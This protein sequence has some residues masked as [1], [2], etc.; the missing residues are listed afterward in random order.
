MCKVVDNAKEIDFDDIIDL[1]YSVEESY[2]K[3]GV[4]IVFEDTALARQRAEKKYKADILSGFLFALGEFDY[5]DTE[6]SDR[7]FNAIVDHITVHNDGRL[8]F[9]F[10]NGSEETMMM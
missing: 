6:W 9:T 8:I 3:N 4:L 10:R 2:R 7:R 1:I 5:L